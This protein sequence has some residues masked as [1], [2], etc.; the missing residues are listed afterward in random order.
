MGQVTRECWRCDDYD[1]KR[2][3]M[4]EHEWLKDPA[5]PKP[6]GCC[7]R[8]KSIN[9][10]KGHAT[11]PGGPLDRYEPARKPAVGATDNRETY[12]TADPKAAL[13]A[14]RRAKLA[15]LPMLTPEE[16]A[17]KPGDYTVADSASADRSAV[18]A[19]NSAPSRPAHAVGCKCYLCKPAPRGRMNH[20]PD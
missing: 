17:A 18:H 8:C 1:Q 4:C 2:G 15:H 12:A 7:A 13:A 9:W 19:A 6:P 11:R 16:G 10:N 14:V 20:E 5:A 3:R